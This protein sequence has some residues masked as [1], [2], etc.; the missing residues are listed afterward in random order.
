MS[1]PRKARRTRAAGGLTQQQAADLYQMITVAQGRATAVLDRLSLYR[2]SVL[3]TADSG[4][5]WSPGSAAGSPA[6]MHVTG[7]S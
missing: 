1:T 6:V 7:Q 5:A 4:P 3:G 2:E